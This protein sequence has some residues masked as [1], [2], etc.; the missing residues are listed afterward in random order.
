MTSLVAQLFHQHGK[1]KNLRAFI[2]DNAQ[3]LYRFKP[4][5][6]TVVVKKQAFEEKKWGRII[7]YEVTWTNAARFRDPTTTPLFYQF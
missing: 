1:L 5:E 2:S 6:K 7:I 4:P 3:R